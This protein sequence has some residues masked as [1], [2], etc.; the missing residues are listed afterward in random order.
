LPKPKR[1][2]EV[3]RRLRKHDKQFAVADRRGK[4]SERMIYHP[5]IGGSSA[6]YPVTCHGMGTEIGV[7][8]LK[9]IIRRFNLPDDIFD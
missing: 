6:S 7:G 4:G 3:I 8:M 2:S 1:Y 9:A 5:D